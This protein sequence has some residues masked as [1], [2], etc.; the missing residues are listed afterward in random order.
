MRRVRTHLPS[1]ESA[2][3]SPSPSHT[4]GV[5][6]V[7]RRKMAPCGPT[8]APCST[9]SSVRPSR[10]QVHDV[11]QVQLGEIALAAVSGP[12]KQDGCGREVRPQEAPSTGSHVH[13][14]EVRRSSRQDPFVSGERDGAQVVVGGAFV[15]SREQDLVARSRPGDSACVHE[16]G[17]ERAPRSVPIHHHHRPPHVH[18]LRVLDEGDPV[19]PRG[20]SDVAQPARRGGRV[21]HVADRKLETARVVHAVH[22]GEGLSIRRPVRVLDVLQQLA[23]DAA[24]QRRP[25]EG[26]SVDVP[27][28]ELRLQEQ[29]HLIRRGEGQQPRVAQPHGSGLGAPRIGHEQFQGPARPRR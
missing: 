16:A 19:A 29:G 15:T 26:A 22:D 20:D 2:R 13:Q 17:R 10:R 9:P 24:G 7:G 21:Q 12:E 1:G 5:P 27:A 4:A 3:G 14:E 6:S 25:G 18:L 11:G 8:L 23:R 28:G